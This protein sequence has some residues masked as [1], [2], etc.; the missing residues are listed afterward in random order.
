[1]KVDPEPI[2]SLIFFVSFFGVWFA[3]LIYSPLHK[4][5]RENRVYTIILILAIMLLIISVNQVEV[6]WENYKK[7][8]ALG[9]IQLI[10]YLILYK[11][12]DFIALKKYNRHVYFSCRISNYRGDE[13]AKKTTWLEFF[14]QHAILIISMLLWWKFGELI[15]E[16]YM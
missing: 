4:Y 7:V 10:S 1:M 2:H 3:N 5:L 8:N 11:V 16:K 12:V 6:D 15:A 14:M 9:P 13:E